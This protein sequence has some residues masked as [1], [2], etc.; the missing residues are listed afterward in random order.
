V[1]EAP[2]DHE[3]RRSRIRAQLAA[4]S[5][6]S[7]DGNQIAGL[8]VSART[9]VRYLS[10]FA[11]TFGSLLLGVDENDDALF[12]DGRY[13]ARAASEAPGLPRLIG[14]KQPSLLAAAVGSRFAGRA[15]AVET[16]VLTVDEYATLCAALGK[17]EL[18][19]AGRLVE[20]SRVVKDESE[21]VR[22]RRASEVSVTALE[23]MLLAG[24][25]VGRT[26][27]QIARD[28]EQR[29]L[30]LGADGIAFATIVAVG[31]N[32]AIPH[33]QPTERP[34]RVGDLLKI[35]FGAN[36][37]GYHADCTRTFVAGRPAGWQAE[38]HAAVQAAQAAG[39]LACSED[40]AI[41]EVDRVAR[42]V[43]AD[44]GYAE[45]FTHGLG[46]GVGLEIHEDPFLSAV[47]VDR[48]A[49]RTPVTVEPGIYLRD[50]GGVRIEDTVVVSGPGSP[51]N[52]SAR[53]PTDLV[54]ID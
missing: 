14:G 24:A 43:I 45:A 41:A 49:R 21:L 33:H 40:A 27:R 36:V 18:V 32:S 22:L 47:S 30:D 3:A 16:H 19:P 39:V 52:L 46:H 35:D 29:M 12:T 37:G 28:L 4:L 50:R 26:E 38:I 1:F 2:H 13:D 20:K 7:T 54:R 9:N 34:L 53:L 10:G 8:L 23:D 31:P 17:V 44:A 42:S 51:E 15:L 25:L 11:G 5:A 6:N 48:L